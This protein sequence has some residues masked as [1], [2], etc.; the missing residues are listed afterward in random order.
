MKYCPLCE[1]ELEEFVTEY[2]NGEDM[3]QDY[4]FACPNLCCPM[5]DPVKLE[6]FSLTNSLIMSL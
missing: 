3:S 2:Q 1:Q 5:S 6:A 4:C